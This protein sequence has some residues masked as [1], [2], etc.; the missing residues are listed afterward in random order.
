MKIESN[1]QYNTKPNEYFEV[2]GLISKLQ[3]CRSSLTS[4][5]CRT[6]PNARIP[7]AQI[8]CLGLW[9]TW[10]SF[11]VDLYGKTLFLT[12]YRFSCHVYPM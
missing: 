2:G 6:K 7:S 12:V 10:T 3:F 8:R 1:S 11:S 4:K 9:H 5:I